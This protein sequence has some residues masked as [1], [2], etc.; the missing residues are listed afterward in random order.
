VPLEHKVKV[1][2]ACNAKKTADFASE[3]STIILVVAERIAG[4]GNR[5][6]Q[7]SEAAF[8]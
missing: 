1:E 4:G 6:L 5:P 8:S 7:R 2:L 3:S